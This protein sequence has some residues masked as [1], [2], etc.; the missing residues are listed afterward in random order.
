MKYFFWDVD[1][2]LLLNQRAGIDALKESI[3]IR[4]GKENFEFSHSLAGRTDSFII[5]NLLTDIK[6]KYT[7]SDAAGLLITYNKLLPLFLTSHPGSLLPNVKETL[8]FLSTNEDYRSALLTGNCSKAAYAKVS[9][10]GVGKYFDYQ[11]STFGDISEDRTILAQ[12]AL[13]KIYVKNPEINCNDIIV[14]GDT[15]HD[16]SCAKAI[17]ARCLIIQAGSSYTKEQLQACKPWK[18]ISSLPNNPQEFSNL[19]KE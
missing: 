10:Y 6:G 11:L 2:T 12:A 1:G 3:R 13:Q 16:V 7:S 5:K 18:I 4:F 14:I 15:P 8:E 17:G 19:L 9:H